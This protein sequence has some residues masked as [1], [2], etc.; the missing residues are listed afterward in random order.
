MI[1]P[2][3]LTMAMQR[4]AVYLWYFYKWLGE[5]KKHGWAMIAQ[6][7]YFYDVKYYI[8]KGFQEA[9]NVE[10]ARTFQY[11]P[12]KKGDLDKVKKYPIPKSLFE[13]LEKEKGTHYNAYCSMLTE[14]CEPLGNLIESFISDIEKS[15]EKIEAFAVLQHNQTLQEVASK[16]GIPVIHQE[17]GPFRKKMYLTTMYWDLKNLHYKSSVMERYEAF[18]KEVS[19]NGLRLFTNKELLALMLMPENLKYIKKMNGR[20]KFKLGLALG[21]TIEE[22]Y[23]C[24]KFY[25]DMEMIY[26]SLKHYKRKDIIIRR[27]P[28]EPYGSQYITFTDMM[29]NEGNVVDFILSCENIATVGS[30]VGIE[31]MFYDRGAYVFTEIPPYYVSSHD[32]AEIGKHAE[33]DFLNFFALCYLAPFDFM[34]DIEYIRWRLSNPSETEIFK[35]HLEYYMS[36]KEIPMSVLDESDGKRLHSMIKI[37]LDNAAKSDEEASK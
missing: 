15:G 16:H 19:A 7:E 21:M 8:S 30:N 35:K 2:F 33:K 13:D 25:T 34:T 36:V 31:A 4:E 37:Q 1:V 9:Y 10:R 29:Q 27:H 14:Y 3:V 22:I 6:E 18:K 12:P 11:I 26:Q 20:P 28:G 23:T 17:W 5:C 32:F 24:H